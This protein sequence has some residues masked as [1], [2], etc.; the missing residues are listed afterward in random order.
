MILPVKRG[1]TAMTIAPQTPETIDRL[2]ITAQT[3]FAMLAGMQLDVFTP[4]KDGPMTGDQVAQA[5][6]V[7]SEMLERLMY[8]LVNAGL[9][10][11]NGDAFSNTP[12]SDHFLVTGKPSYIG[13]RHGAFSRRWNAILKTAETVK[14][15][16]PQARI[17]FT[18]MTDAEMELYF[19]GLNPETIGLAKALAERHDF[20]PHRNLLDVGGGAGALAI[21]LTQ[22]YPDLDATIA[23]LPEITP[24]SQRYLEEMDATDRVQ[25]VGCDVV[26]GPIKGSFDVAVMSRFIQVLSAEQARSAIHNVSQVLLPGGVLHILGHILDDSRVSPSSMVTFDL[27]LLNTYDQGRAYT[28]IEHAGWLDDAGFESHDRELLPNGASIITARKPR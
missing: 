6:G 17:D 27:M 4:L 10:T 8:G 15:G 19:R 28:E 3:A 11:V 1:E 23:D 25:V 18:E 12:E 5:I 21:T 16:T 24:I 2:E 14:T 20:T 26:G 13:G 9:L 22:A 7:N